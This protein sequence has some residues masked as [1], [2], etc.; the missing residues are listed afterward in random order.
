MDLIAYGFYGGGACPTQFY[1]HNKDKT[2]WYYFRYRNG[3]WS[4]NEGSDD[5][6]KCDYEKYKIIAEGYEG[7]Y[8]DGY[9]S[10]ETMQEWLK[11][12]NI[13]L[14]IIEVSDYSE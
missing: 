3:H 5:I 1:W 14:E 8:L 4:L 2:K 6:D 13:N 11:K 12:E 7:H 9:C 10:Q